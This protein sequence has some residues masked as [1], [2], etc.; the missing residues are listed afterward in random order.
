MTTLDV[1]RKGAERI[2]QIVKTGAD[3]L[4]EHGFSSLTKR[5]IAKR[6]GISHGNVGYYFPTR[7]SL[8]QA[9]V[10][11]ELKEYCERHQKPRID[12]SDDPQACFDAFVVRWI[13]EYNDPKVRI[14]FSHVIAS[15][16]INKSVARIRDEMYESFLGETMRRAKGLDLGVD[17]KTLESR[18]LEVMVILEGLHAVSAFRPELVESD[19]DFRQRLLKRVNSI[20][21]GQ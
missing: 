10:D 4:L 5:R 7:E 19:Y 6:L 3:I 20:I 9:V 14:F 16:E 13:D 1:T 2:A 8:W 18:V 15:A 21:R 12:D 17:D 11:Y